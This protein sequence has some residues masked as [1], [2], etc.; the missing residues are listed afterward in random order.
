[1]LYVDLMATLLL[2]PTADVTPSPGPIPSGHFPEWY[3][4]TES[5]HH[6]PSTEGSQGSITPPPRAQQEGG[7]AKAS[8][9]HPFSSTEN[10]LPGWLRPQ[11]YKDYGR[12]PEGSAGREGDACFQE[13]GR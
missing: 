10:C 5:L 2:I 8:P 13:D 7:R 9:Y 4:G 12:M 3:C 6:S 1:M 11:Q